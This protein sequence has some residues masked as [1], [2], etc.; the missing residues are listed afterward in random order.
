MKREIRFT[1]HTDIRKAKRKHRDHQTG[2]G[3]H[4]QRP[5]RERTRER[6]NNSWKSE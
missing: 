5:K 4:D 2:S 6:E 1:I 3:E